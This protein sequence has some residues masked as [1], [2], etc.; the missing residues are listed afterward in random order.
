MGVTKVTRGGPTIPLEEPLC[1]RSRR[2]IMEFCEEFSK[3]SRALGGDGEHSKAAKLLG[4]TNI[5][6]SN[7]ALAPVTGLFTGPEEGAAPFVDSLDHPE[8]KKASCDDHKFDSKFEV[9]V[10]Y[11]TAIPEPLLRYT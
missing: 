11:S 6:P 9:P 3:K 7:L 2:G 10:M 4:N 8:R 1:P 5:C